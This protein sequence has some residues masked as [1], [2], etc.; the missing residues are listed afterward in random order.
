MTVLFPKITTT[1][2]RIAVVSDDRLFAEGLRRII[3]ADDSMVIAQSVGETDVALVD[4]RNDHAFAC[5]GGL[6]SESGPAVIFVAAPESDDWALAALDLGVRGVLAKTATA[7]ELITAVRAV[8]AGEIWAQRRVLSARIDYLSGRTEQRPAARPL[9]ERRLSVREQ[10]ISRCTL[11]GCSNKE[12][13]QRLVIS[14]ATV[15]VHL[16]HIFRKLGVRGR[17]EL[18]AMYHGEISQVAT[19]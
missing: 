7:E 19:T 13:A 1:A 6:N 10:Q 12:I 8:R 2:S 16:T 5:G 18:A 3:V 15:K 17:W 4:A 9:L 11:A 14:E